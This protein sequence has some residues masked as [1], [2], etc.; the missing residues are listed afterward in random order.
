MSSYAAAA[1][2]LGLMA[3]FAPLAPTSALMLGDG[4]TTVPVV[5]GS[6]SRWRSASTAGFRPS[7]VVR[8]V[9]RSDGRCRA[10]RGFGQSDAGSSTVSFASVSVTTTSVQPDT[11]T[12]T[13]NPT[14]PTLPPPF[15]G[16]IISWCGVTSSMERR[17]T[18][19]SWNKVGPWGDTGCLTL[20]R[21]F[22][23]SSCQ[24]VECFGG[25]RLGH[26]HGPNTGGAPWDLDWRS[27]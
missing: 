20:E 1:L 2:T 13:V 4:R 23:L 12:A 25:Q 7:H 21:P 19:A 3:Q 9:V 18:P 27:P 26:D 14:T 6:R 22:Q 15:P 10:Q 8:R 24:H 16:Q 11:T 5:K 17:S